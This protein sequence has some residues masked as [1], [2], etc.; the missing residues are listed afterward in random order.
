MFIMINTFIIY[1]NENIDAKKGGAK[2]LTLAGSITATNYNHNIK[3]YGAYD[4][5]SAAP[6]IK[7][8]AK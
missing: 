3:I 5:A 1:N 8:N 7:A 6:I 4:I 2:S